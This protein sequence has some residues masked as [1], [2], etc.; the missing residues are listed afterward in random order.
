MK[1]C[2]LLPD[3]STTDVDYK[4][5]DPPRR[6]APLL[7]EH[8]V[9]TVF[10]N[11][12]TTYRQLR[13]LGR[14]GYDCFVNLCEGYLEWEV[15]SI[16]V[17]Q[18]LERLQLPFTGPSSALY[19]PDK[20]VMKYVA[21]CQGIDV[22][23]G[24]VVS[25]SADRAAQGVALA[26]QLPFPLFVKPAKAGDSLGVDAA[27][28]VH[29]AA[30]LRAKLAQ[31]ATEYPEVMVEQY[32][33]G[34]EFTVLVAAGEREHEC[35]AYRPLEYRFPPGRE[36]KTYALKTSELH[37][38]CNV[39]CD[40][41][42]LD[43]RLRAAA[44]AV[45]RGFSGVGYARMDFRVSADGRIYFLEVNFTCSVFYEAG[46]EGSADHILNDD[47]QG[48]RGFLLHIV[49]EGMARHRRRHKCYELRGNALQ[50][51]GIVARRDIGRGEIVFR[52][53][54]R[55][56]RIATRRWVEAHWDEAARS[57][58]RRYAYP[59]SSEVYVLW[60]EEPSA[61]APQNHSCDANTQF[62]GLNVVAARD[63]GAG[64]ELT[65]DYALFLDERAEPF[66]CRCG[67]VRCR[68]TIRGTAGNT[69]SQ[70]ESARRGGE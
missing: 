31:L 66:S 14:Q 9:D 39:P 20:A 2:V 53:E 13:D 12:L 60:D 55:A 50:G 4:H 45:F 6:L 29:D 59:L 43:A 70:R 69:L 7:P 3:Y 11:K 42:D 32:I 48:K 28:L 64:E 8:Q 52:G 54:E 25:T 17:I 5:Y 44:A 30:G 26:G 49:R 18:C 16:D 22:P 68:G 34:R 57:D 46:Y 19:D 56:Q 21:Y 24:V 35:T 40:D 65:L 15:P 47:A 61:W 62:D 36:F 37:G 51:Y 1:L 58:F 63:I 33:A 10:L 67:S 38:D 23:A 27:S 41:P